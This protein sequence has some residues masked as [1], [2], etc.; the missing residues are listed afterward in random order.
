VKRTFAILFASLLFSPFWY[1]HDARAT[2]YI[3][4]GTSIA[5]M[6]NGGNYFGQSDAQ[7]TGT[8]FLGSFS[9]YT[10]ITSER[11]FFHFE[12][13][14]QNRFL[15]TSASS[16]SQPLALA[17]VDPA[18]RLQISRFY[19]GGGYTPLNFVSKAGSGL[20]SL[21]LAPSTSSY[22]LEVG[23]IWRVT[24]EFQVV[25]T[26][27]RE[28]GLPPGGGMSPSPIN[29]YGLRFRF[30]LNPVENA[31]RTASDFDGFRYPFGFMK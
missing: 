6:S 16:D 26:V 24:P 20:S 23:G 21:H 9:F 14:L 4:V 11:H 28:Y 3:E 7:S 18:I 25:A 5:T 10:P 15:T 17:S 13:G 12:L 2:A 1:A 19:V 29:E 31:H 22:F 30:P 8:G 27:A